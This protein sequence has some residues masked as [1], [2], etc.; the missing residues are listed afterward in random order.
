V[1]VAIAVLAVIGL[2]AYSTLSGSRY[3]V[4]V[5]VTYAGHTAC[6]SVSARS[7]EAAERT[8]ITGACADIASGVTDTMKCEQVEPST[9]EWL[10]RPKK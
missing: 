2:I 4:H 6:K 7:E 1:A 10:S 5:C 3:R 8:A 9:V